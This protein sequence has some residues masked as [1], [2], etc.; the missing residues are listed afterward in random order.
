VI[1]AGGPGAEDGAVWVREGML[2]LKTAS[3]KAK[4]KRFIIVT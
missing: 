1:A 3:K 2:K 4:E